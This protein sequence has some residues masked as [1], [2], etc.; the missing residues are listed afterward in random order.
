MA[1][2][3][4]CSICGRSFN[5]NRGLVG[6]IGEEALGITSLLKKDIC[7][8]CKRAQAATGNTSAKSARADEKAA[9]AEADA[10]RRAQNHE[11]EMYLLKLKAENP[12][13]Y[14][15][16]MKEEKAKDRKNTLGIFLGFYAMALLGLFITAWYWGILAIIIPIILAIILKK[17]G[18]LNSVVDYFKGK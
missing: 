11:K 14:N 16:L 8:D 15:E 17:T 6:F 7:P 4:R 13:A 18:K 10:Q 12:Q 5:P 1:E 2:T 9:E 3:A